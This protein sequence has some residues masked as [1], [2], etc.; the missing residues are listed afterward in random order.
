MKHLENRTL[1]LM[2]IGLVVVLS[3]S[4]CADW[5]YG[6]GPIAHW[7]LDE[8]QGDTAYDS[9]GGHNGI[10]HGAQWI[11]GL[12]DGAL[13]FDGDHDYITVPDS[14]DFT[15][16]VG[17]VV[18]WI[19]L[20][21]WGEHEEGRMMHHITGLRIHG[22]AKGFEWSLNGG[23]LRRHALVLYRG[24]AY[25]QVSS[26]IDSLSLDKWHHIAVVWDGT[27]MFAYVDGSLSGPTAPQVLNPANPST[28]LFLGMR[29]DG[30]R[31]F[32]GVMDSVMMFDRALSAEEIQ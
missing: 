28:G 24:T 30:R 7:T 14:D 11:G 5:S 27:E 3:G 21:S 8:G 18:A 9:A 22:N 25:S 6:S 13:K 32:D 17:T 31:S 10:V 15:S 16:S 23:T 26:K 1:R 20:Y 2:V 29:A 4:V 12:I 19:K